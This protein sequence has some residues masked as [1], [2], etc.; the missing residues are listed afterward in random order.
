M[1]LERQNKNQPNT[2]MQKWRAGATAAAVGA[3]SNVDYVLV[4]GAGEA[5][6][7][8]GVHMPLAASAAAGLATAET[9]ATSYLASKGIGDFEFQAKTALGKKI[10]KASPV[11][12]IWRG[13]GSGVILDQ[14]NGRDVTFNRRLVH[15]V[16]YG[17]AV[18]A[19]VATPIPELVAKVA[20]DAG[21]KAID[22]IES[23]PVETI[24]GVALLG[25][26][27]VAAVTR[28]LQQ[29]RIRRQQA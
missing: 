3:W 26:L 10:S 29:A 1:L 14:V 15:S 9:L 24:G 18:G 6:H 13:A 22:T 28:R 11:V 2:R 25:A 17:V 16:P 8:A 27:A 5:M 20:T 12:S 21:S 19:W 4:I 7:T 23:Q